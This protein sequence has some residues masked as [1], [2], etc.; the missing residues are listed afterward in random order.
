MLR[1]I[2]FRG[3][4]IYAGLRPDE[5]KT[6][7]Q[8]WGSDHPLLPWLIEK[9]RPELIIEVGSWKG[10]SAINMAKALKNAGISGEVL[11]VDTWLGSPE[12][13]LARGPREAFW[14]SLGIRH[15]RPSLYETFLANVVFHQCQDLITP[16]SLPSESAYFILKKLGARAP[17]IYIDAGHEYPS[18]KRDIEMYWEL[19]QPEGVMILDDYLS[20]PGVTRAVNEFALK[21]GLRPV[22]ERGKV[23]LSRNQDLGCT[24]KIV[25]G[26]PTGK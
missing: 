25:F 11:C 3:L 18:V 4:D 10:R 7:M 9:L 15:G 2:L 13:W 26:S 14:K 8:G 21:Q 19:L 6:D 5:S 24:T 22:G 12:H 20:W 1:D 17:L 16:L 23:I